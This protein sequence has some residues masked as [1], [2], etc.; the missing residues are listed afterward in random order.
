MKALNFPASEKLR[1]NLFCQNDII[2]IPGCSFFGLFQLRIFRGSNYTVNYG[3]L[4]QDGCIE[5]QVIAERIIPVPIKIEMYKTCPLMITFPDE[6]MCQIR[7]NPLTL[8]KLLNPLFKRC[9]EP[10]PEQV[11]E[12]LQEVLAASTIKNHIA[13]LGKIK[14]NKFYQIEIGSLKTI[15]RSNVYRRFLVY[16]L[17]YDRR[18]PVA[19]GDFSYLLS[20]NKSVFKSLCE[21]LRN[22]VGTRAHLTGNGYDRHLLPPC[23]K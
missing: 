18:K 9:N 10:D 23:L 4:T 6:F 21:I 8:G 3:R 2:N 7:I 15:L 12:A 16:A 14:K 17:Q 22:F 11:T 19:F 1:L 5:Y 20:I 13:G